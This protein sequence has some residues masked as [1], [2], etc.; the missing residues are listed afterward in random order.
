[1]LVTFCMLYTLNLEQKMPK[2]KLILGF[3]GYLLYYLLK[4]TFTLIAKKQ[5]HVFLEEAFS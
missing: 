1:M 3:L 2:L 5:L 4:P